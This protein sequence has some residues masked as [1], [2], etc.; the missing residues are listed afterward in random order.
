MVSS[1]YDDRYVLGL[2]L[3][4]IKRMFNIDFYASKQNGERLCFT[5]DEFTMQC[6]QDCYGHSF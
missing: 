3:L 1:D 4:I 5:I 6:A 2:K